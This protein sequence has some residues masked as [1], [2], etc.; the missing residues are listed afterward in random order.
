M[1]K[2]KKKKVVVVS[3]QQQQ[4]LTQE[5]KEAQEVNELLQ[6]YR[7]ELRESI[8]QQILQRKSKENRRS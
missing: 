5:Q 8:R 4:Q 2:H 7:P 1:G 6:V 3:S